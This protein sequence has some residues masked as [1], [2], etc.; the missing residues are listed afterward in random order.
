M[1]NVKKIK[2]F[3]DLIYVTRPFMPP[4]DEYVL[5]LEEIW[6]NR[7]LTNNGPV[8]QRYAEKMKDFLGF[9]NIT[10]FNNGT[11]AL[12]IGLQGLGIS[13]EVIRFLMKYRSLFKTW[14]K[15][16]ACSYKYN[17]VNNYE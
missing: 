10:V 11:L 3:K 17:S 15:I 1:T 14:N 2:P 7:W 12:Q 16:C 8:L 6:K 4:L 13:G 5:G 9:D